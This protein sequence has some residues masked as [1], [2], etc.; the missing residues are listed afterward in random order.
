[1]LKLALNMAERR[2]DEWMAH[3]EVKSQFSFIAELL[4]LS[5]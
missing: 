5:V 4:N 3:S 2:L 1:M